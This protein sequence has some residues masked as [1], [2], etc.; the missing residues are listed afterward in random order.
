MRTILLSFQ[1]QWFQELTEGRMKFEYRMVLPSEETRVFFYVSRPKMVV[2]GIAHFGA[3]EA[4]EDWL[5][6]YGNRSNE[7]K[8]RIQDYLSDCRYAAKIFSFQETNAIPLKAIQKDLPGFLPP[9][10]YYYLDDTDILDYLEKN[11]TPTGN[12]WEFKFS[13][14][15]IHDEDICN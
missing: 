14:S 8:A 10:M 5:N 9:R 7:V 2:T 1:D 13:E 12:R 3:R 4:L 11:L 15:D 6:I